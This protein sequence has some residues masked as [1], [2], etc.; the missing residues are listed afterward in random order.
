[1]EICEGLYLSG[2]RDGSIWHNITGTWIDE[3]DVDLFPI[4][5]GLRHEC[6]KAN[7]DTDL[8]LSL[9]KQY[10]TKYLEK[11]PNAIKQKELVDMNNAIIIKK[12]LQNMINFF[13]EFSFEP[14]FRFVNTFCRKLS[15]STDLAKDYINNYFALTDNVNANVVND[16]MKSYEFNQ[17]MKDLSIT[18]P[19]NQINSRFELFYGSQGT[20]KTTDAM[21]LSNNNVIVCHS[22]MLPSDLLEDFKFVNGKATFVQSAL[23]KAMI[24]GKVICLDEINLLPFE[25]LRFLQSILDNKDVINYKGQDIH[26]KEGFKI[27]GTMNLKVNGQTF[28]LPEPLV[29]RADDIK[30]FVLTADDLVAATK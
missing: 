20:G 12:A 13:T 2:K 10:N 23:Q 30:K 1:M 19:V 21:K 28:G 18:K 7:R 16:K 8:I 4:V 26:I 17:I 25:S 22:A 11:H 27:I 15:K 14:N 5:K 3:K 24:E 29:D 9:L 6:L